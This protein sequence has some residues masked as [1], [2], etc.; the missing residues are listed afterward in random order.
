MASVAEALA[1]L[2]VGEL[3][4]VAADA[5]EPG[6]LRLGDVALGQRPQ[7]VELGGDAA[8][9]AAEAARRPT[10]RRRGG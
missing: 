8:E 6:A 1:Q 9:V 4:H 10:R 3:E 5:D 7:R 2:G